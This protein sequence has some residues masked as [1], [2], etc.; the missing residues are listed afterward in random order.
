MIPQGDTR[1]LNDPIAQH[2]LAF[3]T[4]FPGGLVTAGLAPDDGS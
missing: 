2:M 4:R 1:L 3:Q